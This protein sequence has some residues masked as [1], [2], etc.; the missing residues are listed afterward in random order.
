MEVPSY[1]L[2]A[3]FPSLGLDLEQLLDVL[4]LRGLMSFFLVSGRQ[5]GSIFYQWL[6]NVYETQA[7]AESK[8]AG[9]SG[10]WVSS[11]SDWHPDDL[12]DGHRCLN[13]HDIETETH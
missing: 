1:H 11:C 9:V 3:S 5:E 13:V 8:A 2:W 12:E 6:I 10:V 7:E 4:Q